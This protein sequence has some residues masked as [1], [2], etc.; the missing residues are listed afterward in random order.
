MITLGELLMQAKVALPYK[1]YDNMRVS[2]KLPS[3]EH[4]VKQIK[5]LET[6]LKGQKQVEGIAAEIKRLEE[7]L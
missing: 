2:A 1:S 4:L 7:E 6:I 5:L 3:T